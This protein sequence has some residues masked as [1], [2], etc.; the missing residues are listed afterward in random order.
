[1]LRD[2]LYMMILIGGGKILD[3]FEILHAHEAFLVAGLIA[4]VSVFLL[5][6][7]RLEKLDKGFVYLTMIVSFYGL[8][9]KLPLL[10]EG[11]LNY[12]LIKLI[13]VLLMGAVVVGTFV[14]QRRLLRSS[15]AHSLMN[16]LTG[17]SQA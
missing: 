11:S 3:S 6:P 4:V 5:E 16:G 8:W 13:A 14:I 15:G 12:Y 9:F 2:V 7:S 17:S 10:L 1:M